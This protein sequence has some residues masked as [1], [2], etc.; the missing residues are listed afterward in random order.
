MEWMFWDMA[1]HPKTKDK[2][3]HMCQIL[4]MNRL[5][6]VAMPYNG[7]SIFLIGISTDGKKLDER[8]QPQ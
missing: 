3:I 1:Q 6:W 7:I 4:T 8:K 5:D 2:H